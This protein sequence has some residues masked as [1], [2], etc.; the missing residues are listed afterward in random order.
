L[1]AQLLQAQLKQG[2]LVTSTLQRQSTHT[3][4]MYKALTVRVQCT[5]MVQ[6]QES[7]QQKAQPQAQGNL[8]TS[9]LQRQSIVRGPQCAS[10]MMH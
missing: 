9:T 3:H 6:M 5:E 8:V 10:A 2:N 1:A 4:T 7:L